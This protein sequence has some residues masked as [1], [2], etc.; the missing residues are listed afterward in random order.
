MRSFLAN[1]TLG[2]GSDPSPPGAAV[3]SRSRS[4]LFEDWG[5]TTILLTDDLEDQGAV[6]SA[7]LS[8]ILNLQGAAYGQ[9]WCAQPR[10]SW[11]DRFSI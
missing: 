2:S 4:D 6:G 5:S 10:F 3:G 9:E 7:V 8:P 1:R 11:R